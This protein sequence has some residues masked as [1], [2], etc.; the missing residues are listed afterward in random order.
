[1]K[2]ITKITKQLIYQKLYSS[3]IDLKLLDAAFDFIEDNEYNISEAERLVKDSMR[4][5]EDAIERI[6]E[7]RKEDAQSKEE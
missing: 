1:M 3:L 2:M 6:N 7:S 4:N 5:I